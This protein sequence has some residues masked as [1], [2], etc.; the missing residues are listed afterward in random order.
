MALRLGLGQ[1]F[2]LDLQWLTGLSKAGHSC[3][4]R[5]GAVQSPWS[6][7]IWYSVSYSLLVY[8]HARMHDSKLKFK[9]NLTKLKERSSIHARTLVWGASKQCT[10]YT[11]HTH[12]VTDGLFVGWLVCSSL[13]LS[14]S[15][16]V[17]PS[18][19]QL[20]SALN[21]RFMQQR[22]W[23]Q[24]EQKRRQK[25]TQPKSSLNLA[26]CEFGCRRLGTPR[27]GTVRCGTVLYDRPTD[28]PTEY[29]EYKAR[30]RRGSSNNTRSSSDDNINVDASQIQWWIG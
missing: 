2:R 9:T 24:H 22:R 29:T 27:C 5:F 6:G 1:G 14:F 15:Q 3:C 11:V 17:I 13:I 26:Q 25:Q 30:T 7:C 12:E 18:L 28:R 4:H 20:A 19:R 16:F 21:A 23:Q 10:M 8:V